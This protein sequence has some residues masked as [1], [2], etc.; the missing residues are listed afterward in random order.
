LAL[1]DIQMMINCQTL[2]WK[3]QYG[4]NSMTSFYPNK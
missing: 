1:G 2:L 4:L 3:F